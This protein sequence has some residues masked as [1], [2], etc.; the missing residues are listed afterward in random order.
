[1]GPSLKPLA[2]PPLSDIIARLSPN[3][4]AN[5]WNAVR[6]FANI[7][8]PFRKGKSSFDHLTRMVI[9]WSGIL[10]KWRL[11]DSR[12]SAEGPEW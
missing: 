11:N 2:Q 5:C 7:N 6:C 10:R 9:K 8:A 12:M 3:A 1:M 4:G